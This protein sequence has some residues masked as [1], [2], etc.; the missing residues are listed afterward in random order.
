MSDISDPVDFLLACHKRI[1]AF[2]NMARRIA[3]TKGPPTHELAES[4]RQLQ[5]FFSKALPLHA[6]DEDRSI[7]PRLLAMPIGRDVE[8][9]INVQ[10]AQ[11]PLI[12]GLSLQLGEILA[13]VM[14][15]P[16]RLDDLSPSVAAAAAELSAI[17]DIHLVNEEE[18]IFPAVRRLAPEVKSQILAEF[19]DRGSKIG[20]LPPAGRLQPMRWS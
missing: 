7:A 4:A 12:D 14:D 6:E 20:T 8:V 18:K 13:T 16:A 19:L 1:R 10:A 15:A 11:H 3:E 9:A 2:T 17:W 5:W